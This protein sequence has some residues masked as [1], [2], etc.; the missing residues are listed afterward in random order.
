MTGGTYHRDHI[1]EVAA[2]VAVPNGVHFTNTEY[3]SLCHTSRHIAR[4]DGILISTVSEKCGITSYML[5]NQPMFS[6]VFQKYKLLYT[7]GGAAKRIVTLSRYI[8]N[9]PV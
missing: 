8:I 6:T 5:Y 1:T 2:I 3:S 7:R 4:K 9:I